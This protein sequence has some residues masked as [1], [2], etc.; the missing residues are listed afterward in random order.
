MRIDTPET[1]TFDPHQHYQQDALAYSFSKVYPQSHHAY[2]TVN[3]TL[4][5]PVK[6]HIIIDHHTPISYPTMTPLG[7]PRTG[8]STLL[9]SKRHF[10]D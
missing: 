10:V 2:L 5:L 9:A 4:T 3:F 7:P 6:Q 8:T 1:Q